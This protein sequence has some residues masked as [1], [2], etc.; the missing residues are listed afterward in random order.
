MR[1]HNPF[2][3]WRRSSLSF[4]RKPCFHWLA[5]ASY[6]SN[7]TGPCLTAAI[8]RR[9]K[10]SSQ[11]QRSFQWKLHSHWLKFLRQRHVAVV[12]QGPAGFLCHPATALETAA[13]P[14]YEWCFIRIKLQG[15]YPCLPSNSAVYQFSSSMFSTCGKSIYISVKQ[16]K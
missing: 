9:R 8:W 14:T 12:R 2:T 3:Q 13:S 15:I 6:R 4:Q 1:C 7:D 11:W 10:N 5:K 16:R